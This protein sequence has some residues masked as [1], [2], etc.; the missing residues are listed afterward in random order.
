MCNANRAAC[1]VHLAELGYCNV[2]DQGQLG[3]LRGSGIA[4]DGIH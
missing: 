1:D 3:Q 4:L 2:S